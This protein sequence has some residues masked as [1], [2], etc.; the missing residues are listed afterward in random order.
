MFKKYFLIVEI[1]IGLLFVSSCSETTPYQKNSLLNRN[2][3]RSYEAAIYNQMVNP[4][5][6]KNLEPVLN[7]DGAAADYNV[8]KYK[9]SF[10]ETEQKEVVNIL[11][12]Q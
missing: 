7:L 1:V 12:L 6:G 9:N 10:K 2:W 5:A 3:G 11:K 8:N 4:D